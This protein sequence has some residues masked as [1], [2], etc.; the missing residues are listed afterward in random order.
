M[1]SIMKA[2]GQP[3]DLTELH[4]RIILP[5]ENNSLISRVTKKLGTMH[6]HVSRQRKAR[7][8]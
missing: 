3:Q 7:G 6:V 2:R 4:L 1:S 8:L 5:P